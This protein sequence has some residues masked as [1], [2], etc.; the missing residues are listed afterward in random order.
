MS[1]GLA[2][3]ATCDLPADARRIGGPVAEGVL[4]GEGFLRLR[5][6]EQMGQD[7]DVTDVHAIGP[8]EA[9]IFRTPE[10]TAF[11][12]VLAKKQNVVPNK[13]TKDYHTLKW[14]EELRAQ[15]A[16]KRVRRR[17]LARMKPRK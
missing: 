11:V 16:E 6:R 1:K 14:E 4:A 12:D 13:N 9:A 2:R 3:S 7:L 5:K 8:L 15:I 17:N 10:G